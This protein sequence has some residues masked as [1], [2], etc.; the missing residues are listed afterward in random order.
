M[1]HR[2]SI[3]CHAVAAILDA[4]WNISALTGAC[5]AHSFQ[6][7]TSAVLLSGQE[8]Q[9][10]TCPEA[11]YKLEHSGDLVP[12]DEFVVGHPLLVL[13]GCNVQSYVHANMQ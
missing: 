3:V 4:C 9:P 7:E 8:Q 5:P 6:K 12:V 10:F 13:L 1:L 2:D 11:C